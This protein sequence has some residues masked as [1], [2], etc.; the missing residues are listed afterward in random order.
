MNGTVMSQKITKNFSFYE[1]RPKGKSKIWMPPSAYQRRLIVNLAENLQIVRSA[2]PKKSYIQITSGVRSAED[3]KRLVKAGYR[4]SKTSDHNCGNAV[5]LAVNSRKYKK[6][7][8]TYNFSTGAADCV[9]RGFLVGSLFI[10]AKELVKSGKCTFG[11]VIYEE[12]PKTKA[13][14]VHFSVDPSFVFSKKTVAFINRIK[15]LQSLD[16]G[17]SYQIA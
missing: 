8:P 17:K 3:Y 13:K 16:G 6:Y 5:P 11:Q 15:F 1:F 9:S 14:W 7:G 12:N 10:L 4:P 2:M